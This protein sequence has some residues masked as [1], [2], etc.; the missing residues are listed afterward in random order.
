MSNR[1][2]HVPLVA[3]ILASYAGAGTA[4]QT[5]SDEYLRYAPPNSYIG[6][7]DPV[8]YDG[9]RYVRLGFI[10]RSSGEMTDVVIDAAGRRIDEIKDV[11]IVRPTIDPDAREVIER[12][13]TQGLPALLSGIELSISLDVPSVAWQQDVGYDGEVE[14]DLDTRMSQRLDGV[15]YDSEVQARIQGIKRAARDSYVARK[16][17]AIQEVKERVFGRLNVADD[18]IAGKDGDLSGSFRVSLATGQLSALLSDTTGIAQVSLPRDAREEIGD[19]LVETRV[20]PF[21]P[22]APIR[23]EKSGVDP[24]SLVVFRR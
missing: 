7:V 19:A 24:F 8:L 13:L 6:Y 15:D 21:A 22:I 20:D 5:N 11:S 12:T 3:A 16:I 10:D 9:I 4:Q 14:F 23:D 17:S 18:E 2:L 1:R